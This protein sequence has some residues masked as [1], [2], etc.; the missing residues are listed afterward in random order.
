MYVGACNYQTEME[1]S[2]DI[3]G[4]KAG[5]RKLPRQEVW[6]IATSRV[7]FDIHQHS[8][9]SGSPPILPHIPSP[10]L[11]PLLPSQDMDAEGEDAG[12]VSGE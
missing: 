12:G 8:P 9:A 6:H 4:S 11:P 1:G 2:E 5:N 7:G 10:L 3:K